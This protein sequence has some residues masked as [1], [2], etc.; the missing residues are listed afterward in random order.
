MS[1]LSKFQKMVTTLQPNGQ[2]LG[3]E[4]ELFKCNSE[5]KKSLKILASFSENRFFQSFYSPCKIEGAEIMAEFQKKA[6]N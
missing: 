4:L 3:Q 6:Y 2:L 5:P 1:I